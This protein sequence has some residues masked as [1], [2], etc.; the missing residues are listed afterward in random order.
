[1]RKKINVLVLPTVSNIDHILKNIKTPINVTSGTYADL[2]FHISDNNLSIIFRGKDIKE[3]DSVWL[4]SY[5]GSR[6]LA[7]AVKQYLKHHNVHHTF[8][9]KAGSKISDSVIFALRGIN[10]PNTFFVYNSDINAYKDILEKVCGYPLIVKD[11]KGSR[12]IH[13][14]LISNADEL[15]EK[16][17][18][19][20]KHNKYHFQTYIPN[21]HDWGVLISG[22]KVV[23]GEK[24][25]TASGEYRNN[26]CNGATEVFVKLNDI[27]EDIQH[28]A[29]EAS[30]ALKLTWSRVDIIVDKNTQIPYILEVNRSP[31]ITKGST[32]VSGAADFLKKFVIPLS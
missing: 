13:S 4:S 18:Q 9:E 27:P 29:L 8:V 20:P 6:D 26:A 21:D 3:F 7:Y 31:G 23:S 11:I 15:I 24:S 25:Y 10:V 16:M 2:E 19:L 32:E 28:I 30:T 14:D 12:G 1:M 5:W 22:G 17:S